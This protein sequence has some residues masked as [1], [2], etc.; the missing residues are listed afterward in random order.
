MPPKR[1]SPFVRHSRR[2]AVSIPPALTGSLLLLLAAAAL[3]T[4]DRGMIGCRPAPDPAEIVMPSAAP[5]PALRGMIFPTPQ[6]AF[7]GPDGDRGIQPTVSGR[8]ES[9]RYG[10]TRTDSRGRASFHEGIDIAVVSRDA[11]GRPRDSATAVANGRVAHA[12]RATGDS[13]YGRYVVLLHPDPAGPVYTL[14][15]H[16]AD[17]EPAVQAGVSVTRGARLGTVGHTP[18]SL[19]PRDRAHLHF[20]IGLM[21]NSRFTAWARRQGFPNPHGLFNGRNLLGVDPIPVML[22]RASDPAFSML[23]HLQ[24][25]SVAVTLAVQSRGRMPDFFIR[26]PA[27]WT[28]PAPAGPVLVLACTEGGVPVSGR[29]ATPEEAARL[30][31]A[32][33]VVLAVDEAVLGRNGRHLVVKRGHGWELGRNGESWLDLLLF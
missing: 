33:A 3:L 15:A 11:K 7:F 13:N 20:E 32:R 18:A 27:L 14:Y 12:N 19:I 26:H 10:S 29:N 5:H 31:R 17:I 16:L 9:G 21:A 6:Q 25:R 2:P 4:L 1:Q 22:Q 23:R 24:T 8:P 30:G 28:D